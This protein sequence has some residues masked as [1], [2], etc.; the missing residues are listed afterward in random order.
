MIMYEALYCGR[1]WNLTI[2]MGLNVVNTGPDR[3]SHLISNLCGLQ[4][5]LC[6]FHAFLSCT[7]LLHPARVFRQLY[8]AI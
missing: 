7:D 6:Y 4:E 3:S 5:W 8:A 2:I 1:Q